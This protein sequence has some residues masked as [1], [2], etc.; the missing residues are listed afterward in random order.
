MW[1]SFKPGDFVSYSEGSEDD[2][3]YVYARIIRLV[4]D[5]ST[6]LEAVYLVDVG[7]DE[8]IEVHA[9][10]LYKIGI[11]RP[12]L[13][14]ELVPSDSDGSG[15]EPPSD[16]YKESF[17]GD[18]TEAKKLISCEIEEIWQLPDDQRRK[19]LRRLMLKWHPD[20]HPRGTSGTL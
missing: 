11:P 14:M 20:K 9:V 2:E 10:D 8:P 17:S 16:G 1:V 15:T 4:R 19:A 7:L 13:G 5:G 6:K 12:L 3:L 18:I